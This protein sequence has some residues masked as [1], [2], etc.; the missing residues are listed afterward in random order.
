MTATQLVETRKTF[1]TPSKP[2]TIR[3]AVTRALRSDRT[4]VPKHQLAA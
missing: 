3:F 4:A 1:A 2:Y